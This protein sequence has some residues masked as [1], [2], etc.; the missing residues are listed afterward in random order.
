MIRLLRDVAAHTVSPEQ[1]LLALRQAPFAD[2][3]YA[4]IDLHR[5]VR[6]GIPEVIYGSGKTAAQITG[7]IRTMLQ[8]GQNRILVTR[9]TP[10]KADAIAA[11]VPLHYHAG[12]GN[13][14]DQLGAS[15]QA[16]GFR[17]RD[18]AGRL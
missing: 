16:C 11:A 18:P 10:E 4:K 7:I 13:A 12:R 9:I 14:Y 3:D 5:G 2:I 6:Q 1:A 15:H 8:N 17:D